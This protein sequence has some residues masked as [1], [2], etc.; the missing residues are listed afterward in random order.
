MPWDIV[1][2]LG[3][4]AISYYILSGGDDFM[5][6]NTAPNPTDVLV[7]IALILL[8]LESVRRTNGMILVTVTILFLLYA[9]FGN[10]LPAPW[11]HKGYDLDRLVGY[12]YMTLEGIY[13][14]A[15]DV[16]ATLII[17]FT[18]F[19]ASYSL[20]AQESFLLTSLL[21]RWAA[22]PRVLAEQL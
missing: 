9:L 4:I 15:V 20:L 11:T 21:Q 5:D 16:S 10:H 19:G 2:A 13:G 1:F 14:T 22:S 17:L 12:M 6:R 8:I 7:G 18:I 3:S